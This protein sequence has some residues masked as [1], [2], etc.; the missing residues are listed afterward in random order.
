MMKKEFTPS[1][2]FC[3]ASIGDMSQRTNKK[4]RAIYDCKKCCAYYCDQCSYSK[5]NALEV[6]LCLRCDSRIEKIV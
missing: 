2:H 3:G 6:Q 5:E 1:C 4:T